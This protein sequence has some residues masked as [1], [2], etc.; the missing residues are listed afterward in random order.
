MDAFIHTNSGRSFLP[1]QLSKNDVEQQIRAARPVPK[2]RN[3][4]GARLDEIEDAHF[5][6]THGFSK[7]AKRRAREQR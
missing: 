1:G 6:K 5:E 3:E 4:R 2:K 7:L